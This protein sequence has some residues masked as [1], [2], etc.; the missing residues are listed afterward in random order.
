LKEFPDKNDL[1]VRWV[2]AVEDYGQ[3]DQVDVLAVGAHPDDVEIGCGGL[4]ALAAQRNYRVG[5]A[6]L[7][8]GEMGTKGTAEIRQKEAQAAASVLGAAFRVNLGLPDTGV[9]DSVEY[10]QRLAAVIRAARPAIVLAPY[11]VDR[12]P[13]HVGASHLTQRAVLYAALKKMTIGAWPAHSVDRL[14]FYPINEETL[15]SFVTDITPVWEIK[16]KAVQTHA[17][18]FGQG[19]AIIDQKVF[20][21]DDYLRSLEDRARSFG[22]RIGASFGE[23]FILMDTIAITD[24]VTFFRRGT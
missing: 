10:A 14:L 17:S 20:G 11:W 5:I 13:D 22:N 19:V 9:I 3:L 16:L 2:M 7:T 4:L 15:P 6:D 21:K 23:G 24:P 8:R 1:E 12:H 18:Q